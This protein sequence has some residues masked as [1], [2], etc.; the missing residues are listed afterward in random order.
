[1]IERLAPGRMLIF[2]NW[3]TLHGRKAYQG[4][5]RLAGAYINKEDVESRLRVLQLKG[6]V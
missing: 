6:A 5:R 1:M 2:D 3:R 4:K